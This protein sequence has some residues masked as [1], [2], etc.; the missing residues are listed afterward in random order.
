[1]KWIEGKLNRFKLKKMVIIDWSERA[2]K[3]KGGAY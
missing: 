1:M 3:R 2:L